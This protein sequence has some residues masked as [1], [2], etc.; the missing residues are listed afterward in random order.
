MTYSK[1]QFK[2]RVEELKERLND[3]VVELEELQ[4]DLESES[5]NIEIDYSM[6]YDKSRLIY[7]EEAKE[8]WQE[9]RMEEEDD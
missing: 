4:G 8:K 5:H 2:K 9:E 3:L 7:E 6:P 1:T